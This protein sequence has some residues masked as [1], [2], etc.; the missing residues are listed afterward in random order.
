MDSALLE[1]PS[2]S[3]KSL[4]AGGAAVPGLYPSTLKHSDL[5]GLGECM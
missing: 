1:A 2:D 5:R 3:G 4:A